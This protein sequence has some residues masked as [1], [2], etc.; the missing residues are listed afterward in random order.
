MALTRRTT[1]RPKRDPK[2]SLAAFAAN[3]P[4][5]EFTAEMLQSMSEALKS[6]RMK[7]D[8]VTFTDDVQPGLRAIVRSK[9]A[10][11]L[12]CHYDFEGSRPMIK[13]GEIPGCTVD[14]AR[15]LTKTIR[16]LAAKG[17]DVQSG[18]HE[19]LLRELKA[20]GTRWRP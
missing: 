3:A 1:P 15:A 18:L 20:Q 14:E 19:R 12:H 13:V 7:V 4:K 5:S 10:I 9:G 17:I 6:G 2:A 11:T 16:A 8:K